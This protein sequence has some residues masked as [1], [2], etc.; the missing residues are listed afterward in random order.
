LHGTTNFI[1]SFH[2]GG[3][4]V[5]IN[6]LIISNFLFSDASHLFKVSVQKQE[7]IQPKPKRKKRKI[8]A[9]YM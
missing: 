8:T 3:P 5:I 1:L 9:Q 7:K 4:P 2:T 6:V